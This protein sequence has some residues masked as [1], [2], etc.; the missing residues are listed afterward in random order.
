[1]STITLRIE[2]RT[3]RPAFFYSSNRMLL[4]SAVAR[5]LS[6]NSLLY[7]FLFST[8]RFEA[9]AGYS[10]NSCDDLMSVLGST[11]CKSSRKSLSTDC[12]TIADAQ[13]NEAEPSV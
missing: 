11:N 10:V 1:M 2:R 9:A 5:Y 8:Y 6:D 7:D 12:L 3:Q 13:R 4:L